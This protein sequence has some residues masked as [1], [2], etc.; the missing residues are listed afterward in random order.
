MTCFVNGKRPYTCK[1]FCQ[2]MII[3]QRPRDILATADPATDRVFVLFSQLTVVCGCSRS[4]RLGQ[5]NPSSDG[6]DSK[7][8]GL[9]IHVC[10]RADV[11]SV[12]ITAG[13]IG[14]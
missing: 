7:Q 14:Y 3:D 4:L 8:V 1:H 9:N 13:S 12:F 11:S 2:L 6:V 5:E 10:R